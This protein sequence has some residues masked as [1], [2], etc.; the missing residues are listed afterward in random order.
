M[1][2]LQSLPTPLDKQLF[3]GKLQGKST[4][5]STAGINCS[6]TNCSDILESKFVATIETA[7]IQIGKD[8]PHFLL[9]WLRMYPD[10]TRRHQI[11]CRHFSPGC[12]PYQYL[13]PHGHP[14]LNTP[15]NITR[16]SIVM[17]GFDASTSNPSQHAPRSPFSPFSS[18][19]RAK[20]DLIPWGFQSVSTTIILISLIILNACPR[21]W[22]AGGFRGR[23]GVVRNAIT[24]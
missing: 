17:T 15:A 16:G 23:T 6:H 20:P 22:T 7:D 21:A 10:S 3:A 8:K 14:S 1:A 5:G 24:V 13:F 2:T 18:P 9:N 11:C 12:S 19:N 4:I